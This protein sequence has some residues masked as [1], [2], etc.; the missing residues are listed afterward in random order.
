MKVLIQYRTRSQPKYSVEEQRIVLDDC[1]PR[2]ICDVLQE[3]F[4]NGFEM[5]NIRCLDPHPKDLI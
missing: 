2:V 1:Y 4:D 5:I 3:V